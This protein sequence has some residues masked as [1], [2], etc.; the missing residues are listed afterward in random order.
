[1]GKGEGRRANGRR[2]KGRDEESSTPFTPPLSTPATQGKFLTDQ[3]KSAR[4][5]LS[6]SE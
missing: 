1:M 6:S 3:V 5:Q 4:D 2:R